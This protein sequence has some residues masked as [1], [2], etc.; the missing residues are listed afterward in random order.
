MFWQ[1]QASQRNGVDRHFRGVHVHEIAGFQNEPG[2]DFQ[3]N[4]TFPFPSPPQGPGFFQPPEELGCSLLSPPCL[5]GP[6][7]DGGSDLVNFAN[8]IAT[9]SL[10]FVD[11]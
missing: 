8:P 5:R 6:L 10:R 2:S 1:T 9:P 3:A 7:G 11:A 4:E